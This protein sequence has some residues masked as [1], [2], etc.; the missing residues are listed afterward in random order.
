MSSPVLASHSPKSRRKEGRRPERKA[1]KGSIAGQHMKELSANGI[2]G[3]ATYSCGNTVFG[4]SEAHELSDGVF[5]RG[6]IWRRHF[7]SKMLSV[8]AHSRCPEVVDMLKK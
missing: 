5:L 8:T 3:S 4:V 6:R 2:I 7:E 1:G